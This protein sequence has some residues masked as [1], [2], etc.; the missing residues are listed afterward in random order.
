MNI[1]PYCRDGHMT[2]EVCYSIIYTSEHFRGV[3]VGFLNLILWFTSPEEL[4]KVLHISQSDSAPEGLLI[5]IKNIKLCHGEMSSINI[6]QPE[7]FVQKNL[8]LHDEYSDNPSR[9]IFFE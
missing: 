5:N 7:T 1:D 8:P 9:L 3:W 2:C 4:Q 6:Y